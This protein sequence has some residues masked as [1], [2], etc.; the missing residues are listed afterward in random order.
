M[1]RVRMES[2]IANETN[3]NG[4]QLPDG[5]WGVP[6]IA[7]ADGK[8]HWTLAD[9]SGL[10]PSINSNGIGILESRFVIFLWENIILLEEG[11]CRK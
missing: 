11:G 4:I 7:R 5:Q 2:M 6:P 8:I 1:D 3:S 10:G 9:P